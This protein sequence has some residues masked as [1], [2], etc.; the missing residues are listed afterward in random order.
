MNSK[1]TV[2]KNDGNKNDVKV[3]AAILDGDAAKVKKEIEKKKHSSLSL[4]D[5]QNRVG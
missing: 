4:P 5:E 2:K 3:M 1:W